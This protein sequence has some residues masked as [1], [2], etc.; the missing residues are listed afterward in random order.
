VT[1]LNAR[2]DTQEARC[3][4]LLESPNMPHTLAVR[5]TLREGIATVAALRAVL[6]E[7]DEIYDYGGMSQGCHEAIHESVASALETA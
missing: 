1:D 5:R 3:R 6:A 7:T 2:L 4:A